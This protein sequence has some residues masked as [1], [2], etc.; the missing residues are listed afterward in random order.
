MQQSDENLYEMYSYN[1]DTG[2]PVLFVG[3]KLILRDGSYEPISATP[4]LRAYL[5][6]SASL[7]FLQ[8]QL[9]SRVHRQITAS[10]L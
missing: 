8:R 2:E 5:V 6:I 1:P 3:K 9:D 7:D 4:S 10:C